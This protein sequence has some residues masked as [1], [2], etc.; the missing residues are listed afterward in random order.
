PDRMLEHA[1]THALIEIGDR[2]QTVEGAKAASPATRRA[3]LIAL[4]QMPGGGLGPQM[5]AGLLGSPEPVVRET[6]VWIVG[7]R[8][9][10]GD[11]LGGCLRSRLEMLDVSSLMARQGVKLR[12]QLVLFSRSAAV[13]QLL[14]QML[15]DPNSP[16][17]ARHLAFQAIA[18]SSLKESPPEWV[19]ALTKAL[20]DSDLP[21]VEQAVAAA[22]ALPAAKSPDQKYV[23][24]LLAVGERRD[25]KAAVR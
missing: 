11:A 25:A 13:Q 8:P 19:A 9:Q 12:D 20:A 1:F 18:Q 22:R 7:R 17:A 4:D 2:E 24:S 21:Q 6:A 14:A 10:W 15:D 3:A 16:P 5:V 23:A